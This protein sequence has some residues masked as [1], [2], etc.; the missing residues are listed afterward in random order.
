[1]K[2]GSGRP[3]GARADAE[4]PTEIILVKNVRSLRATYQVK[5]LAYLAKERGKSLVLLLPRGFAPHE[6]LVNL[7]E[8]F[9]GLIR[10]EIEG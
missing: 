7:T 2:T 3:R 1:M 5:L 9:P 8:R 10:T 4:T 6:S